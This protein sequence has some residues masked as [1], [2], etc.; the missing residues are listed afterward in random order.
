MDVPLVKKETHLHQIVKGE[1]ARL[2]TYSL[3]AWIESYARLVSLSSVFGLSPFGKTHLPI[4]RIREAI[5]G[6][7]HKPLGHALDSI[8]IVKEPMPFSHT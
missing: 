3:T 4:S 2:I 5:L 1:T 7:T 6:Y 8:Q